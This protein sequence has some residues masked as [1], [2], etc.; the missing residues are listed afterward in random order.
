MHQS[1]ALLAR[2]R[3]QLS[4][5]EAARAAL[6]RAHEQATGTRYVTLEAIVQ[7]DLL[8]HFR[9]TGEAELAAKAALAMRDAVERMQA[10]PEELETM[11]GKEEI[12]LAFR[13]PPASFRKSSR[14]N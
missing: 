2:A 1:R 4:Q 14:A 13:P 8:R 6:E 10:T 7:R 11:L 12:Q 5:P 9:S 3:E